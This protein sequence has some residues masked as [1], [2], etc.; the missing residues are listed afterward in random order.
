[1]SRVR[2]KRAR[3]DIL[4]SPARFKEVLGLTWQAAK[5]MIPLVWRTDR[6]LSFILTI[7]VLFGSAVPVLLTVNVGLLVD[8]LDQAA[9]G[10]GS[11]EEAV[12]WLAL[13]L[14]LMLIAGISQAVQNYTQ[15]RLTD[16]LEIST[17]QVIL[18]HAASLDLS[19]FED[20]R[21]QD[22]LQRAAKKPGALCLTFVLRFLKIGSATL[23]IF[24]LLGILLYIEPV[25]TWL[26]V[27]IVLPFLGLQ[28]WV[29]DARYSAD[30]AKTRVRRW[31]NYYRGR[32]TTPKAVSSSRLMGLAPLMQSRYEDSV[33]NALAAMRHTYRV[34][35]IGRI[36][37]VTGFILAF[38]IAVSV[39]GMRVIEESMEIGQFVVYWMAAWR[40]KASLTTLVEQLSGELQAGLAVSNLME[41]L[42]VEPGVT[43]SGSVF[44]VECRG[45]IEL[46]NVTFYYPNAERPAL[47]D[48]SL[49][50]SPGEV[51]ALVGPNGAGKSTIAKLIARL[52]DVRE[53]AISID[54]HDIRTLDHQFLHNHLAFAFQ[55]AV[56][57]EATAAENLAFGDWN[58]LVGQPDAIR[59]V[60]QRTG[61]A[62]LIEGF[63]DGYDT[64][65]GRVFGT[66][67]LSGGQW[68]RLSIARAL[69]KD[70]AIVI[71]D[72]PTES[73]DVH[74]EAELYAHVREIVQGKTT[75]LISHRLTTVNLADRVVYVDEGQIIESGTHA[76]LVAKDGRYAALWQTYLDGTAELRDSERPC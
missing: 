4:S 18:Q 52:Y 13:A 16:E 1:M 11:F 47:R 61:V 51:I 9:D 23:Q 44:P 64:M 24:S 21:G 45:E 73:L 12:V 32:L 41:F 15:L 28:T 58:R 19:F 48:V 36:I 35:L 33:R 22:I 34:E 20:S 57:F 25:L 3:P 69:A 14:G 50:V 26:L 53:G 17:S 2:R 65:L 30:R 71:M 55:E 39:Q 5:W 6:W 68:R 27:L 76:E 29:A 75:F 67:E 62:P 42:S 10:S 70:A 49:R 8:A 63:P 56:R 46:Q 72:E 60:A 7:A 31:G 66:H 38:G 74:T 59:E 40:F 54:G 37:V 43:L